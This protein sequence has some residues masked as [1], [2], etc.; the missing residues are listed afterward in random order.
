MT[1]RNNWRRLEISGFHLLNPGARLALDGSWLV[2]GEVLILHDCFT[3]TD[4]SIMSL[5]AL[6]FLALFLFGYQLFLTCASLFVQNCR[7]YHGRMCLDNF[8]G[9]WCLFPI[10]LFQT[11][12]FLFL[13]TYR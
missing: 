4:F 13:Y 6:P 2:T 5:A 9:S 3:L 1:K 11:I 10:L 8:L 12:N 7:F